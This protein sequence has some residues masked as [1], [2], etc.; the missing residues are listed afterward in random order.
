MF[1]RI[2]IVRSCILLRRLE[3]LHIATDGRETS[4]E[5]LNVDRR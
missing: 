1:W 2:L 5:A 4:V 3:N